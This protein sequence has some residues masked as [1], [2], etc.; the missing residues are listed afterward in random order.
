MDGS[1]Y[2]FIVI[3]I[4]ALIC[5][6]S[7][8]AIIY[9]ADGHPKTGPR[10]ATVSRGQDAIAGQVNVPRQATAPPE[11]ALAETVPATTVPATTVPARTVPATTVPAKTRTASLPGG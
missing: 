2:D 1:N 10:P 3:P 9:W 11:T 7:W 4:V 8:L 6:A 5:L